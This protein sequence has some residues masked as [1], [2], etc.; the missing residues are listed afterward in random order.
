M[1]VRVEKLEDRILLHIVE[2]DETYNDVDLSERQD[3]MLCQDIHGPVFR[4]IDARDWLPDFSSHMMVIAEI[5]RLKRHEHGDFYDVIVSRDEM[6]RF[7]AQ[8]M[9]QTQYGNLDVPVFDDFESAIS[10]VHELLRV[11]NVS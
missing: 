8:S 5:A 2:G 4:I 9:A 1:S 3:L 11:E 10:Y 6:I 7:G